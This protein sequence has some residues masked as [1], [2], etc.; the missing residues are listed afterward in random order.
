MLKKEKIKLAK[1]FIAGQ[2]IISIGENTS[3]KNVCS[4]ARPLS[5]S[6]SVSVGSK[7]NGQRSHHAA[8]RVE[9]QTTVSSSYRSRG[10]GGV[11]LGYQY[12]QTASQWWTINGY[13]VRAWNTK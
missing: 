5:L 2:C 7:E 1:V 4:L 11:G 8:G 6:L 12:Q 10:G 3:L 13:D 9:H